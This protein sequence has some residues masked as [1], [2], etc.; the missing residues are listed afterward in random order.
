MVEFRRIKMTLFVMLLL[1]VTVSGLNPS[2]LTVR[3]GHDV[4]LT[5]GNVTKHQDKCDDTTWLYSG[6]EATATQ[7][8]IELGQIKKGISKPLSDRLSLTENCSLVIKSVTHDDVGLYSCRQFNKSEQVSD[9]QVV[10]S[11]VNITEHKNDDITILF[12]AALSYGACRYT[13]EWV[14]EGNKNH[15]ETSQSS[16][17]ATVIF[18]THV[19]QKFLKCNV[20][21]HERGTMLLCGVDL[22][23]SCEKTGSKSVEENI[24]STTEQG[25]RWLYIIGAVGLA[26]L[27]IIVVAVIRQKKT[28]GNQTQ[29]GERM[30]QGLNPAVTPPGPEPSQDTADPEEGVSYA[31]ISYTNKTDSKA[32]GQ[33]KEDDEDD[34]VT[35]ST[36]KASSSSSSA[37]A[38]ADLSNLY[39]TVDKPNK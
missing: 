10:L 3:A 21:D 22:Q 38:A 4:T 29:G 17:S 35:Y 24:P 30:G 1:Q 34:A 16:C 37:G 7:S 9:A 2:I 5:C 36:V 13:V 18:Q 19:D 8:L 39:A 6:I 14:N 26:A 27:L 28:K 31:S 20:T 15:L 32:Q 11:V 33:S 12:C 25:L 23:S